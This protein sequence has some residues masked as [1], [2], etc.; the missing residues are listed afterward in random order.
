[1]VYICTVF[2][3][4]QGVLYPH[5]IWQLLEVGD[6]NGRGGYCQFHFAHG[7]I[8]LQQER[9][10]GPGFAWVLHGRARKGFSDT[11]F[12]NISGLPTSHQPHTQPPG[13]VNLLWIQHLPNAAPFPWVSE[14]GEAAIRTHLYA[15][16]K[17]RMCVL[18]WK[19]IK[20]IYGPN[21]QFSWVTG[22]QCFDYPA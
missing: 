4:F 18:V 11:S 6:G 17:S 22:I 20:S 3:S 21:C 1:M 12:F 9:W 16:K 10:D 7:E 14:S 5:L 8:N 15:D 13:T 2:P 19:P